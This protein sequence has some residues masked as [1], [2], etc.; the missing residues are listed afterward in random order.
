MD[1]EFIPKL[2]G[3]KDRASTFDKFM[4]KIEESIK[5]KRRADLEAMSQ[6]D[7]IYNHY[8]AILPEIPKTK[9]GIDK[10]IDVFINDFTPDNDNGD[11]LLGYLG[12][13]D[14]G[15]DIEE[16]DYTI[17]AKY[18]RER[19]KFKE[20]GDTTT[21]LSSTKEVVNIVR[22]YLQS[23]PTEELYNLWIFGTV[24]TEEEAN[25]NKERFIDQA[26]YWYMNK[27]YFYAEEKYNSKAT[28]TEEDILF[29]AG[30][31]E[32]KNNNYQFSNTTEEENLEQYKKLIVKA[33]TEYPEETTAYCRAIR[34]TRNNYSEKAI[35]GTID[36]ILSNGITT[37]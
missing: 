8:T 22:E 36:K 35:L 7:K 17:R 15:E 20:E 4:F 1:I 33:I 34:M 31:G 25:K 19:I 2:R 16:G 29:K 3:G 9:K 27:L 5:A 26:K 10:A 13:F 23:L 30:E 37:D 24:V 28:D 6:E 11:E 18:L 12:F 32:Y 21:I 14:I